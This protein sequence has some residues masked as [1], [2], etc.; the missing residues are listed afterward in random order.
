ML[1]SIDVEDDLMQELPEYYR[2]DAN[3]LIYQNGEHG[4]E[5]LVEIKV[6]R[7]KGD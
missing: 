7:L 3:L 5:Y 2:K 6:H 4:E 1:L